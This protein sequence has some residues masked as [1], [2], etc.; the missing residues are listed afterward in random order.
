MNETT[1]FATVS[2]TFNLLACRVLHFKFTLLLCLF[3]EII[4]IVIFQNCFVEENL[5]THDTNICE[6]PYAGYLC[7]DKSD[8]G[9]RNILEDGL[10]PLYRLLVVMDSYR[11]YIYVIK[12][13]II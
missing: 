12:Q 4:W 3:S 6:P 9:V 2:Y 11:H 10:I 13:F 1:D 8:S 5:V 7:K